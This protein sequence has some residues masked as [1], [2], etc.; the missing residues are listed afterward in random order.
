MTKTVKIAIVAAGTVVVGFGAWKLV[1]SYK[2]RKANK[3]AKEEILNDI[4]EVV[5]DIEVELKPKSAK[6][7]KKTSQDLDDMLAEILTKQKGETVEAY[8]QRTNSVMSNVD[9]AKAKVA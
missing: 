5:Q 9:E 8:Q 1:K 6:V 3:K 7:V 2:K 4:H